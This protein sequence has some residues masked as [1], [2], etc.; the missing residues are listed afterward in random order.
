MPAFV[1]MTLRRGGRIDLNAEWYKSR[2]RGDSVASADADVCRAASIVANRSAIRYPPARSG[3]WP[4]FDGK[5]GPA[6]KI[7]PQHNA[8]IKMPGRV[9]QD[10]HHD[11]QAQQQRNRTGDQGARD[12]DAP[13]RHRPRI[14]AHH[15][16]R[17]LHR[18]FQ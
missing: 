12:D 11:H 9:S 6:G 17:S 7:S 1:G 2:S 8:A 15:I 16:D 5:A 4:R 13:F 14:I 10:R 3:G 18:G